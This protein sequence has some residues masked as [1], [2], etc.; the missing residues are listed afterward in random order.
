MSK[1][2]A[3]E[4]K[5]VAQLAYARYEFLPGTPH[6]RANKDLSFPA[7]A[8]AAGVREFWPGGSK[9]PAIAQLLRQTLEHRRGSFCLVIQEIVR[10]ALIYLP[11]IHI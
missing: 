5:A 2:S 11:L 1:L 8:H 6:P 9:Q 7:A 3:V 4:T 10:A